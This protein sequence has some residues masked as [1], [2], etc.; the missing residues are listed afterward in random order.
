MK[1]PI[2]IALITF[3]V[4]VLT[5]PNLEDVKKNGLSAIEIASDDYNISRVHK[6]NYRK[7]HEFLIFAVYRVEYAAV[8][9]IRRTSGLID[10]YG[11]YEEKSG[12]GK[13]TFLGILFN[14]I[15]I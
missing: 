3:F 11:T 4:L 13:R 15:E 1:K 2:I 5:K 8:Q 12:F 6:V 10:E 7:T 9:K 14:L